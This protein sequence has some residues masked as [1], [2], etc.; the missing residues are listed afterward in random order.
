[1]SAC[2]QQFPYYKAV[3]EAEGVREK[4]LRRIS[5]PKKDSSFKICEGL[6]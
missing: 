2:L 5:G 1:M 4:E 3:V 6:Q